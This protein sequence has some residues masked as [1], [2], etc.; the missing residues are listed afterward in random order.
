MQL[1]GVALASFVDHERPSGD[2]RVLL[3][4]GSIGTELVLTS[5]GGLWA[6]HLPF[7]LADEEDLDA[8]ALR[9]SG[10]IGAAMVNGIES[11]GVGAC[12]KHYVANNQET[13]RFKNESRSS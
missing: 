5:E 11:T 8:L 2:D 1:G 10:E 3:A 9:L 6:R 12:V 13:N 4:V 7:G